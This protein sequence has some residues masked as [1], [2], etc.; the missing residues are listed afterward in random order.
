MR[1]S[2]PFSVSRILIHFL[3]AVGT[4]AILIVVI[5]STTGGF[6]LDAGPVH[7]SAH[8][9]RDALVVSAAAWLLAALICR[10]RL[11]DAAGA[12]HAFVAARAP[13]LG[14]L[15]AVAAAGAGVAHGNYAASGS[16]AAGYV[17]AAVLLGRGALAFDEPLAREVGWPD[18]TVT[19]SPLGYRPGTATGELAPTYP[20]GL[21]LVMSAVGIAGG[22]MTPFLVVPL[23]GALAVFSTYL[24]GAALHSRV[25]GVIAASLLA[26]SPIFLFQ[27]GQPMSDV[28]VTAWWALALVFALRAAYPGATPGA[29]LAAGAA[30]GLAIL[31]RP[32]VAPMVLAVACLAA[33]WPRLAVA[34]AY[35]RRS[36][37][38]RLA[39]V[40]AGVL[41]AVGA[42]LLVQWRL[43][44]TPFSSGYGSIDGFFSAATVW[45]NTLAYAGRL[46]Q[47]ELPALVLVA[48]SAVLAVTRRTRDDGA[49]AVTSAATVAALVGAIVL[50]CYLPYAEFAEWS[51]LRF[52]L[53]AFP[54]LFALI[55]A[56]VSGAC[57]RL[58]L[59]VR[60]PALLIALT[61][62]AS[63][64]VQTARREQV[65][66]LAQ[67][68]ARYR[69]MGRY[70][71]SALP[72][73]AVILSVQES[74]SAWHYT[75]R[76]IVRWDLLPVDLDA[77]LAVLR[78]RGREPFLLIEDWELADFR[79]KFPDALAAGANGP[80]LAT[81]PG[82]TAVHLFAL[83]GGAPAVRVWPTDVLSR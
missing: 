79:R 26:S 2:S 40:A 35:D 50:V 71:E 52:L 45:P 60:G 62:V 41:P 23:L 44:G 6:T 73:N 16:D 81:W 47:G 54:P 75:G 82:T 8:R 46:L 61:L 28:A 11:R 72:A 64:N 21:P 34:H 24:L 67:Y 69:T 33:G 83:P 13:T 39:Y 65:F 15:I 30:S 36:A 12:I 78:S 5:V 48:V 32:N 25:A 55:G 10:A 56:L 59:A 42:L 4:A 31:T 17:S 70:L 19:F 43:Y 74:A 76:P 66:N 58:P 9:W 68:E 49:P 3:T 20:L 27:A 37:L 1:V 7:L 29:A 51:Y 18:A 14:L 77:A 53:P 80:S 63:V 22:S 38:R 57:R